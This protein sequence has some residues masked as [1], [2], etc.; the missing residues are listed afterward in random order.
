MSLSDETI[1]QRRALPSVKG[2]LDPTIFFTGI[3]VSSTGMTLEWHGN[4]I[5]MVR[6]DMVMTLER[7]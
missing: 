3:P 2:V 1:C 5:E 7:H 6:D 4:D